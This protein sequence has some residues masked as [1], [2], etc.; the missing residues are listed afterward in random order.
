LKYPEAIVDCDWLK[1]RLNRQNIR[2]FDCTTY[3]HYKDN[4]PA[5][6]YDVESGLKNYK[7][8]NIPSSAFIDLQSDLSD[9]NSPYSFT[10]PDLEILS[11][12]FKNLGIGEHY[13]II[14]YSRNVMQWSSR[15]C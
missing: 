8:E 10:L 7:L 14:L 12:R 2:V 11:E 3:L 4:N 9:K 6:P 15:I 13:H 5:K 1:S